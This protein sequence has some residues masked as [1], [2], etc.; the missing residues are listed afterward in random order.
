M[1][2]TM[3][4]SCAIYTHALH[5]VWARSRQRGSIVVMT[6]IGISTMVI[7]LASIDIGYLF[8]QKRELQKVA[9]LSAL[10][11]AQ[12]LGRSSVAPGD[13]CPSSVIATA[14]GNAKVAQNFSGTV[15]ASCGNWDPV[16]VTTAPHYRGTGTGIVPNA[17]SVHV[18]RSF[19]SFFGA[20]A[21][22][23]VSAVAIATTDAPTAVF[24]VG[25]L[26][27]TSPSPRDQRGSRMPSS[28]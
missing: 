25:C 16:A 26:L 19:R 12:Q 17:V 24:S 2:K 9:D 18:S 7:L 5:R 3:S 28:A 20:W 6:A 13:A 4:D 1:M 11:G 10:A 23:T 8:F 21:S 22:R 27:Y 14:E 15:T